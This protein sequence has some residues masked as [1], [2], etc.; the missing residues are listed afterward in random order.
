MKSLF[1]S[2]VFLMVFMMGCATIEYNA[3]TGS[4]KYSRVG[5]QKIEGLKVKKDGGKL[6]VSIDETIATD[7]QLT[8][9]LKSVR[10]L[11]LRQGL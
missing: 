8:E 11:L 10:E 5:N 1:I 7:E 9:I 4:F 6:S 3:T 2:V